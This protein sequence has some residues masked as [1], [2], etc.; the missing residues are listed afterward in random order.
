[1]VALREELITGITH[2]HVNSMYLKRSPDKQTPQ[3]T[4]VIETFDYHNDEEGE[5][6]DEYLMDLLLDLG[7]LKEEVERKV[8]TINRIDIRCH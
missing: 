2:P 3:S 7:S 5:A 4:L 1:M 8:G 6:R